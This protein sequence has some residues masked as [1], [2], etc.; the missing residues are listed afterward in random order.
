MQLLKHTLLLA[1]TLAF[2]SQPTLAQDT[3]IV[4]SVQPSS[5]SPAETQTQP[6]VC[7]STDKP[8]STSAAPSSSTNLVIPVVQGEIYV[9][10]LQHTIIW[11]RC[12]ATHKP[13]PSTSTSTA[14]AKPSCGA[15]K[16]V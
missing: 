14:S 10:E 5:S 15:K 13:S 2:T 7:Y 6:P 16:R 8:T 9:T 4:S 3:V 12:E 1:A 11:R